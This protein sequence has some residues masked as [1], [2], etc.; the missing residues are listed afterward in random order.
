MMGYF[1]LLSNRR[2]LNIIYTHLTEAIHTVLFF[3]IIRIF[4]YYI[5]FK[6]SAKLKT[7]HVQ[8]PVFYAKQKQNPQMSLNIEIDDLRYSQTVSESRVR[9][10]N[11]R[12]MLP[13]LT[14]ITFWG[15]LLCRMPTD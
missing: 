7:W 15:S 3:G 13:D 14:V 6:I 11:G 10:I 2:F 9:N 5:K 4:P 8:V 1:A 12:A